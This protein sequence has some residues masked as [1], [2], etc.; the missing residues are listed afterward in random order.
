MW[1]NSILV[2]TVLL[3]SSTL[4]TGDGVK[5]EKEGICPAD[6][7]RCIRTEDPLCNNDRDCKGQQKCCYW[8]CGFKCVQPVKDNEQ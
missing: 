8:R 3:I 2:L 4:V 1:P 7:V 5:G 6:I